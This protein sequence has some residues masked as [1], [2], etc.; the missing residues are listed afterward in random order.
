MFGKK[1]RFVRSAGFL[2]PNRFPWNGPLIDRGT[3]IF[4]KVFRSSLKILYCCVM[5]S[6]CFEKGLASKV[7]RGFWVPVI[8]LGI[9]D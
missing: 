6:Q 4:L 3:I 7:S 1:V 8:S 9:G 5:G 2:G